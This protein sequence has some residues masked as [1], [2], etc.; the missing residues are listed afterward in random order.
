MS[1]LDDRE[2]LKTLTVLYVE[3][4]DDVRRQLGL[5]LSRRVGTLITAADGVEGLDA[6]RNHPVRLVITDILMPKLDGLEMAR[7]IRRMD[8]TVPI[9]VTTAFEQTDYLLDSID[10]G[11]DGYVVKPIST[12]KLN[13]TLLACARRLYLEQQLALAATVF[14][15]SPEAIVITD[16]GNRIVSVNPAF[17]LITGYPAEEV[18]GQDPRLLASGL[19]ERSF[20]ASMWADLAQRKRWQGEI[21]NRRKDGT[22]F[23]AWLSITAVSAPDGG[24]SHYVGIF[25]DI[26]IR[27]KAEQQIRHLA[28]HDPLTGLPNRS[29]LSVRF[30]LALAAAQRYGRQ[31]ALLFVDLDDFKEVNDTLGHHAGDL[32]LQEVGRRLMGLFRASDTVSR[33]GGDEFLIVINAVRETADAERA[34]QK[35]LDAVGKEMTIDG[36]RVLMTPSVGIALYPDHGQDME[37]LIKK[38]DQSMYL[39]KQQGKQSVKSSVSPAGVT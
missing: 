31:L 28:M 10:L 12:E 9:I 8:R 1:Q 24:T 23:P 18:L 27:K 22:V 33:L 35:V 37:T 15:C 21:S 19:Q 7:E 5:F 39:K 16:A 20:F 36:S 25:S 3:D 11:V 30:E 38:A 26:T 32:V 29:L 17:S 6:F 2:F 34:A 13:A 14:D 4:D